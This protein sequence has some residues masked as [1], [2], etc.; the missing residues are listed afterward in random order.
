MKEPVIRLNKEMR[1]E[2][3]GNVLKGRFDTHSIRHEMAH[4]GFRLIK[5]IHAH[6]RTTVS[7][8]VQE[9][10]YLFRFDDMDFTI[11][12]PRVKGK[13]PRNHT[14]YLQDF[15]SQDE[16]EEIRDMEYHDKHKQ[17][18]ARNVEI[19]EGEPEIVLPE[20][21]RNSAFFKGFIAPSTN[22]IIPQ[23]E[24]YYWELQ[25][26]LVLAEKD[27]N[28]LRDQTSAVLNSCYTMRQLVDLWPNVV[29]YAPT[30]IPSPSGTNL[31]IRVED[32][33]ALIL[34]GNL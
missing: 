12:E 22:T 24:T 20:D 5:Q 18:N 28:V 30:L 13:R 16:Y 4:E 33:D 23:D 14:T 9:N 29:D 3:L 6:F 15:L 11:Y 2:I 32:I 21:G 8:Y 10:H 17:I 19:F 7:P 34:K 1:E 27:L 31:V 25:K 26:K